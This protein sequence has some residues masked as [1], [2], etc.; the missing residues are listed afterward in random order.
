MM[1]FLRRASAGM[2]L[3]L[4]ALVAW[5]L[6]PLPNELAHPQPIASVTL[7]DRNGLPLRTTRSPEGARAGWLP[8]EQMDPDVMRAFVAAE[9]QRFYEHNGVD[10]QS[11]LRALR[12]NVVNRKVVSGA[13]TITMQTARLLTNTDRSLSGKV[14]QMLW[15][16]RLDAQLDKNAILEAYL[17]RVPLGEGTVGVPAAASLY[18]QASA[19]DLSRGQAA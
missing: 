5:M 9:D 12:D 8:I 11:L 15:A 7:L 2:L 16:L 4:A 19:A 6:W 1:T 18:F 3:L 17:N 13:S 14:K 10:L